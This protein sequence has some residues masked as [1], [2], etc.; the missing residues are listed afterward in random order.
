[1]KNPESPN[2]AHIQRAPCSAAP[3]RG[4]RGGSIDVDALTLDDLFGDDEPP[5]INRGSIWRYDEQKT[6]DVAKAFLN[7]VPLVSIQETIGQHQ[8]NRH[9]SNREWPHRRGVRTSSYS[10]Q[11]SQNSPLLQKGL[12]AETSED[13]VSDELEEALRFLTSIDSVNPWDSEGCPSPS[14]S[15]K[16][17][18]KQ[19]QGQ[20]KR[21]VRQRIPLS[22]LKEHN[23]LEQSFVRA[24]LLGA[25]I[26]IA[27]KKIPF[28]CFSIRPQQST[29]KYF[30]YRPRTSN[31][32]VVSVLKPKK[33]RRI[34]CFKSGRAGKRKKK[35]P[36]YSFAALLTAKDHFHNPFYLDDPRSNQ[37]TK[38][39]ILS[40]ESYH[41]SIIPFTRTK[42]LKEELNDI[43]AKKHPWLH[44]SLTLS[45]L[46]NL[47]RDL[48]RISDKDKF[49]DLDI[50]TIA[51][52]WV[53]FERLILK[54]II[55]KA[56]RKLMA[57]VCLTLAYKF[58]QRFR[59]K[60]FRKFATCIR[61]MDRKDRLNVNDIREA[62]FKVFC[63]LDFEMHLHLEELLP[64]LE[65]FLSLRDT[66]IKEYYSEDVNAELQGLR[67]MDGRVR[68]T[69]LGSSHDLVSNSTLV[70]APMVHQ[71]SYLNISPV[72]FVEP[73]TSQKNFFSGIW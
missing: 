49:P 70:T 18:K 62:E 22:V 43:F 35:E 51:I 20:T 63:L 52:S 41:V 34:I 14:E 42:R 23:S 6:L 54:G 31:L 40:L 55:H 73:G 39:T 12:S 13:L 21:I 48:L 26:F 15:N 5:D 69:R 56:N 3:T 7:N 36:G 66:S 30:G 10:S 9:T 65:G 38:H 33:W 11:V 29:E 4:Q 67:L 60:M 2:V 25:Q 59:G 61:E 1:M 58:N 57:G 45:K 47:K 37:N 19:L 28:Y 71:K 46:R 32:P 53:Y 50:S 64:Q 27:D 72:G 8:L 68:E 44:K 16:V 17:P 24:G